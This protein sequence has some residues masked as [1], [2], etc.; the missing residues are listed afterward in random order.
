MGSNDVRQGNGKWDFYTLE[1]T[2]SLGFDL[3]VCIRLGGLGFWT[4]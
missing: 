4:L 3:R 2:G 1:P